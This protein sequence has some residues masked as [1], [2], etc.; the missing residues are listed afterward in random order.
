MTANRQTQD[1]HSASTTIAPHHAAH[2]VRCFQAMVP[3]RDGVRLNTFV[4]LPQSGGP[5]FPVILHRT[6]YGITLAGSPS[7]TDCTQGWLPTT[8]GGKKGL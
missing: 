6:P 2:H 1:S 8:R 7:Y 5:R 4:F 3:M